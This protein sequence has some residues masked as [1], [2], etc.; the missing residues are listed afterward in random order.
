MPKVQISGQF[1]QD[2]A[3]MVCIIN[4][5]YILKNQQYHR[6]TDNY[7]FDIEGPGVPDC[8]NVDILIDS[9]GTITIKPQITTSNNRITRQ[10]N[11]LLKKLP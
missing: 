10:I 7:T 4:A 2:H 8:E 6:E 11:A 9:G 3:L 1:I 5:G